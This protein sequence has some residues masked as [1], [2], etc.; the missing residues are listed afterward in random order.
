ML[1][2]IFTGTILSIGCILTV[3]A[4]EIA[5][6]KAIEEF[7]TALAAPVEAAPDE[8]RAVSDCNVPDEPPCGEGTLFAGELPPDIGE[9]LDCL[10]F[11]SGTA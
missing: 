8:L 7:D 1:P 3:Q 2:R 4:A 5:F 10:E 6:D 11:E 9:V